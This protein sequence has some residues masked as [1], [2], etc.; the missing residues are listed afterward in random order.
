MVS[1]FSSRSYATRHLVEHIISNPTRN[2]YP[3]FVYSRCGFATQNDTSVAHTTSKPAR[4]PVTILNDDGRVQ[5][6]DLSVGEKAARTTQ[7][8][9]NFGLIIAG[10]LGTGAVAY[11]LYTEV[12][13]S[14]SKTRHF[15][16]AVD[17]VRADPRARELLGSGKKIFAYGEPTSNRWAKARP[18]A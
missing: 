15:D 12:F 1:R 9:F 18:I 2:A 4:K 8:T 11:I 17:R 13:A 7:Q 10:F 3:L 5:W 14:D 6:K 16:R